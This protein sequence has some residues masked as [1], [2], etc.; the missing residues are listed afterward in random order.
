MAPELLHDT[1]DQQPHTKA[2]DIWALGM[3]IY[4]SNG[5]L[6][7]TRNGHKQL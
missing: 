3:V 1:Q 7:M 2:T 5:L 6:L 4:V